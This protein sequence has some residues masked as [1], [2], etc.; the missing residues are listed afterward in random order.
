VTGISS[1]FTGFAPFWPSDA[2]E[3][4][5][6]RYRLGA[7]AAVLVAATLSAAT[8]SFV[9]VASTPPP[10]PAPPAPSPSSDC[11]VPAGFQ[12]DPQE[13]Q[14]KAQCEADKKKIQDAKAK[15][16]DSLALAQG[17]AQALQGMMKQTEDA[18]GRTRQKED[19]IKAHIQELE[20]QQV[21]T[22]Q[23]IDATRARLALKR[24]QYSLFIRR[25]YKLESNLFMIAVASSNIDDFLRKAGAL[26]QIE[27]YGRDLLHQIRVEEERLQQESDKLASDHAAAEQEQKNLIA[28][29]QDLVS[30]ELNQSSILTQLQ[31][32]IQNVQSE[33]NNADTQNADLVAQIAAA[34]IAR[35]D[36]LINQAN[37][38]AWAAAQAWMRSNSVVFTTSP[39][40]TTKSAFVWPAQTGVISQPFGPSTLGGEP[41]M[42]GAPHF[43][44]GVDIANDAGTPIFAADDG[45]VVAAEDSKLSDG[46]LIGYG[47]HLI[48][49]HQNGLMTLYGHLEG[50]SVKVGQQVRQG[51]F[52]GLMGSTG[53]STG[54]HLHFE[55]RL[56]NLPVDPMPYLPSTTPSNIRQ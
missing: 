17:S 53:Y 54:P 1:F 15:L 46:T 45:V 36:A 20:Q 49:A 56:N 30:Q 34:E 22:Q 12:S 23:A 2:P 24:A 43:H 19:D 41:A 10:S 7:I 48:I 9:V 51:D 35:E 28:T 21:E 8:P 14:L 25:T 39:G 33:I 16:G 13:Q 5:F 47:R 52:I 40:H 6:V 38:A 32:S 29:E 18:I 37:Q 50:Y 11:A 31:S 55:V 4:R 3:C 42:F 27:A 26:S 44:A